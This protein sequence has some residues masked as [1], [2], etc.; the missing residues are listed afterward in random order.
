MTQSRLPLTIILYDGG[1]TEALN[2]SEIGEYL[3]NRL[4]GV[5]A[6]IRPDLLQFYLS[7]IPTLE[8]R[9]AEV[10]RLA[11][12]LAH[13]RVRDLTNPGF[14]FKPLPG[15][16][17]Y[18]RNRLL[19]PG[20]KGFGVL[21]DAIQ[22]Q[23]LLSRLILPEEDDLEYL[24]L[25][26]TNQLFGTWDPGDRRFH[27]RVSLYGFPNLISTTGIVEAPAKPREF[28]LLKR[29]LELTGP[30]YLPLYELKRSLGDMFIDH[31]DPR[32]TEVLKGYVMQALFFHVTGDPFCE[33]KGCRLYNAHWQEE[34]LRAQLNGP[35]EF[36][37]R[38]QKML[39]SWCRT[40]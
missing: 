12:E 34:V 4:K 9:G 26:F 37:P 20:R 39:E 14:H 23:V 30:G 8:Q 10:D 7:S 5:K 16:V 3:R 29:Q 19:N 1:R 32:L 27:A 36:C 25:V 11:R 24:H 2:L 13:T 6:L 28:Y 21:Y 17:D 15:E 33:N 40:P 18:E 31:H 38:H 22:L 35:Y